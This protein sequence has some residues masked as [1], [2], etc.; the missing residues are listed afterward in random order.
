MLLYGTPLR[1][2]TLDH[3]PIRAQEA[4]I[5]TALVDVADTMVTQESSVEAAQPRRHRRSSGFY[6]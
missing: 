5:Q 6:Q 3:L 1:I 4:N 2:G